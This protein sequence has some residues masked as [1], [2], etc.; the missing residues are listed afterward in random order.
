[1]KTTAKLLSYVKNHMTLFLLINIIMFVLGSFIIC[2]I[3]PDGTILSYIS[4]VISGL[5]AMFDVTLLVQIVRE[6]INNFQFL[7]KTYITSRASLLLGAL[8]NAIYLVLSLVSGYLHQS[9]WYLFYAFYHFLFAIVKFLIGQRFRD[10]VE[11]ED[12]RNYGRVGFF[13]LCSSIILLAF[14]YFVSKGIDQIAVNYPLLVYLIALTT[15][16]N[17]I[18][19]LYNLFRFRKD[20]SPRVKSSR[21]ISFS[22]SLFAMF[23]LQ[24]MMLK[25]FGQNDSHE[26]KL[27]LTYSLGLTIFIILIGQSIYMIRK[28]NK[29]LSNS[30]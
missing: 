17:I 21:Q 11:K 2:K 24:T 1:M 23:F 9:V 25:Q 13:I 29:E 4:S 30:Q 28:S 8:Y 3:I 26:S 20:N 16:I 7:Q 5:I 27:F 18:T 6:F 15:F 22:N 12:W 14:L 10:K 19:S